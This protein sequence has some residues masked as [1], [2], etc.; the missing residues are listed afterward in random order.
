MKFGPSLHVADMP[1]IAAESSGWHFADVPKIVF[2]GL[3]D[4]V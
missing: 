2:L 3:L 4:V 1:V